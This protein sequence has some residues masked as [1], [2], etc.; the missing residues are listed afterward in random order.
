M[1]DRIQAECSKEVKNALQS[2]IRALQTNGAEYEKTVTSVLSRM[3]SH[4]RDFESSKRQFFQ[5]DGAKNFFFW[6]S[7]AVSFGTLGL[8]VYVLFFRG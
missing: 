5:F 7:Q 2:N 3:K 6:A 1:R 8:L 4:L